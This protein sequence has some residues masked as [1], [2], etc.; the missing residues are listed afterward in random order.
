MIEERGRINDRALF[1]ALGWGP[2][3]RVE[4]GIFEGHT[5]VVRASSAGRSCVDRRGKVLIPAALRRWCGFGV[6][7]QVLLVAVPSMSAL[8]VHGTETF[9]RVLPDPHRIVRGMHQPGGMPD[10]KSADAQP[11][12][13]D[14]PPTDPSAGWGGRGGR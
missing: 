2:G 4:I 8:V 13:V 9:D 7:E 11:P 3:T 12:G 5:L 1:R 10:A 14:G 6:K